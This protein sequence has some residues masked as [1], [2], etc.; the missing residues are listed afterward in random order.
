MGKCFFEE[1][2]EDFPAGEFVVRRVEENN[3]FSCSRVGSPAGDEDVFDMSYVIKL[4]R[5][6]EEE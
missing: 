2:S 3:N 1:G 6:Y 4:I 5:E